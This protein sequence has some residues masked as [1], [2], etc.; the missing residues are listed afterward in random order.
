MVSLRKTKDNNKK[1]CASCQ[2]RCRKHYNNLSILDIRKTLYACRDFEI[3]HL[4]QRSIFLVSITIICFTGYGYLFDKIIPLEALKTNAR[5][6]LNSSACFVSAFGMILSLIWIFV[7][8]GSKAWYEVYEHSI[9][10]IETHCI[11]MP[12]KFIMGN[13]YST[14]V[15]TYAKDSFKINNSIFSTSAGSFSVSKLNIVLGQLL[16]VIWGCLFLLHSFIIIFPYAFNDFRINYVGL[17]VFISLTILIFC[18]ALVIIKQALSSQF[19]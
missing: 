19:D 3:S 4:W 9:T 16:L 1:H 10:H 5:I 18:G 17:S 12:S 8:K 2:K 15:K 13:L 14:I 6:F 11:D 7:A